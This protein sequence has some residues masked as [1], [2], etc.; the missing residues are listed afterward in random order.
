MGRI[1]LWLYKFFEIGQKLVAYICKQTKNK[2]IATTGVINGEL[3][4]QFS[5]SLY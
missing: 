1:Y 2:V 3:Q 5:M 4:Y